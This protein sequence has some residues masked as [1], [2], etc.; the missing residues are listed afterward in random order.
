MCKPTICVDMDNTICN[1]SETIIKLLNGKEYDSKL[2]QWNFEPYINDDMLLRALELFNQK[3]FYN[4]LKLLPNCYETLELLS[5]NYNIIICTKKEPKGVQFCDEWLRK[6]LP[7]IKSIVYL[8]QDNFDKTMIHAH[9]RI[10]DKVE[11][12]KGTGYKLLFGDYGYQNDE[13]KQTNIKFKRCYNWL[14]IKDYFINKE[15]HIK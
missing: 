14:D 2:L 4:N 12:L 6:H 9:F 8:S 15:W 3:E 1:S 7:F 10:D 5:A 13:I 11:A